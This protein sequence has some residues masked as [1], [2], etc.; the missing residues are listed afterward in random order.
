MPEIK[1][2]AL[3]LSFH[4]FDIRRLPLFILFIPL[5]FCMN[6]LF[7]KNILVKMIF[8]IGL[9][10]VIVVGSVLR[11]LRSITFNPLFLA[12]LGCIFWGLFLYVLRYA[13]MKRSLVG[14]GK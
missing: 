7:R 13:C 2:Q 9:L 6:V 5:S 12:V 8:M 4:A 10:Q 11:P 1:W 14:Q 3:S